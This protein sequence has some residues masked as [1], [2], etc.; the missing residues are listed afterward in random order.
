M[1]IQG[2]QIPMY[3]NTHCF[4]IFLIFQFLFLFSYEKQN[5]A[6]LKNKQTKQIKKK[7]CIKLDRLKTRK[8]NTQV[9][10]KQKQEGERGKND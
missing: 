2:T 7:Q 6:K 8:K 1:D 4:C 5:K 10:Q 3:T 9:M